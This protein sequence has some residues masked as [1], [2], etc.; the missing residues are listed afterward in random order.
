LRWSRV[1]GQDK[2]GSLAGFFNREIARS[3]RAC[4]RFAKKAAELG[5]ILGP[6]PVVRRTVVVQ[7]GNGGLLEGWSSR[8]A[9]SDYSDGRG[10]ISGM[11]NAHVNFRPGAKGSRQ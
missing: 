5:L 7:R 10:V 8:P 3:L 11:G 9:G 4:A 1:A 6:D 2:A